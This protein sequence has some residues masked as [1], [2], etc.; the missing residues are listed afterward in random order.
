MA[1]IVLSHT[2]PSSSGMTSGLV[3]ELCLI[4]ICGGVAQVMVT[5]PENA[6]L[7]TLGGDGSSSDL[8]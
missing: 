7:E 6:G 4:T 5:F 3:V 2:L 1:K 8:N